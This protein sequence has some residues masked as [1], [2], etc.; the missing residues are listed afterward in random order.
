MRLRTDPDTLMEDDPGI[1]QDLLAERDEAIQ[2]LDRERL[3]YAQKAA[4]ASGR[5]YELEADLET[6]K[7]TLSKMDEWHADKARQVYLLQACVSERALEALE[8]LQ[9]LT[10][11]NNISNPW[12]GVTSAVALLK[13]DLEHYRLLEDVLKAKSLEVERLRDAKGFVP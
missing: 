2:Q 1:Y 12:L 6:L 3:E 10:G 8:A 7:R 11:S 4:D 9:E 5:V 13:S